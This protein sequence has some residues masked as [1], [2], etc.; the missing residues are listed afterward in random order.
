ML[1]TEKLE[2][3]EKG[4][5]HFFK[6]LYSEFRLRFYNHVYRNFISG[7]LTSIII[8]VIARIISKFAL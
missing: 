3:I 6:K 2:Y 1:E 8:Y 7:Y 4:L 5:F